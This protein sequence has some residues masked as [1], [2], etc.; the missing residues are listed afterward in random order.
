MRASLS[1][2]VCAA[3]VPL[4]RPPPASQTSR[5]IPL[6]FLHPPSY[7]VDRPSWSAPVASLGPAAA[8]EGPAS[9]SPVLHL[10]L[11][12]IAASLYCIYHYHL[13]K[14]GLRGRERLLVTATP[15]RSRSQSRLCMC[16]MKGARFYVSNLIYARI[17]SSVHA[18]CQKFLC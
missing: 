10:M 14:E 18:I 8:C 17:H 4:E 5:R 3:I 9:C 12:T 13:S 11:S 7:R 1:A 16:P 6:H 2:C 15:A